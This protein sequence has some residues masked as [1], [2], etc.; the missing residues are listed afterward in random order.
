MATVIQVIDFRSAIFENDKTKMSHFYLWLFFQRPAIVPGLLSVLINRAFR[1]GNRFSIITK[2]YYWIENS[3]FFGRYLG[4]WYVGFIIPDIYIPLNYIYIRHDIAIN[5]LTITQR[6][7][8]YWLFNQEIMYVLLF[9]FSEKLTEEIPTGISCKPLRRYVCV[10]VYE[11][12]RP[13]S[14]F[15]HLLYLRRGKIM[16]MF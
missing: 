3:G 1:T 11:V 2:F 15:G 12:V 13:L 6:H 9:F 14:V 16:K 10:Y 5:I 4:S 8:S 7:R